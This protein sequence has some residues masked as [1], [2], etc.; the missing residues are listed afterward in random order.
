MPAM[1]FTAP[2]QRLAAG[3]V[4]LGIRTLPVPLAINS[5]PYGGRPA[6]ARCQCIG[7][8]CPVEAKNGTHNT[9]LAR[10]PPRAGCICC[11]APVRNGWLPGRGA[12]STVSLWLVTTAEAAGGHS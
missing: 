1:P 10:G 3:A 6:C 7:F 8:T 11:W 2:G 9:T 5:V 12:A 4:K